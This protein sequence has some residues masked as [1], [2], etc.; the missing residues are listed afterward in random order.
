MRNTFKFVRHDT[1]TLGFPSWTCIQ[2]KWV[3]ML[4]QHNYKDVH[5]G[6]IRTSLVAQ[7]LRIRLLMQGTRVRSLVRED[8][9]CR[10]ATKPV[11]RNY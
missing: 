5:S 2:K 6:F 9:T 3:K 4:I 8:P 1:T 11:H 10:K 7:W